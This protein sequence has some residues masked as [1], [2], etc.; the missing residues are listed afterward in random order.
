[1]LSSLVKSYRHLRLDVFT[2]R[3]FGGNPLAVYLDGRGLD[4]VTMQAIAREMNLSETTFVLPAEVAATDVRV[5]IFTPDAEL[6]MAGHPTIGTAFALAQEGV[7]APGRPRVVFGLGVGPT[8]VDLTW[9]GS[10]LTFATMTQQPPVFGAPLDAAG[11]GA[12]LTLD[13]AALAPQYPVQV[14]NC[15][16]PYL[17]VP[18]R[19]RADVD[20]ARFDRAAYGKFRTAH[21]LSDEICVYLFSTETGDDDASA[22]ARMFGASI[23]IEEDPATGSACGPLGSYLVRHGIVPPAQA[24]AMTV[25]QGVVMGRPSVMQVSVDGAAESLTRVRVGG[26]AVV[27]GEGTLNIGV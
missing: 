14:V 1:M 27:V 2:T 11:A 25:R 18:L 23:G 16:V 24:S 6:P 8:D 10:Q 7:L 13:D 15:G 5:R 17:L 20:R 3:L 9:Q 26:E 22:Y 21:G 12:A 19:T 4:T